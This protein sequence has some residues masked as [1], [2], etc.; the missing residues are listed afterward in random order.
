MR[1]VFRYLGVFLLWNLVAGFFLFFA[2]PVL[3]IPISLA[4]YAAII[5]GY[6]LR[7]RPGE[8]AIRRRALV[9]LR[10]LTGPALGWTLASV[11]V[12]LLL[13]WS[14]SDVYTRL[15]PVPSSSL[16]PFG[17]LLETPAG[18]LM[19]TIFAI[20]IA[21]VVEEFFFRGLIQRELELRYGTVAGILGG[22]G[23]FAGVHLLPWVFPLH[24]FLGAA[25]GYAVWA[26]RSIWAG[27]ILHT[28]NNVA[29]M[30]TFSYAGEEPV[31][32]GTFWEFGV[33]AELGVSL[34]ALVAT[35]SA[36]I[37]MAGKMLRLRRIPALPVD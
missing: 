34:V 26:T 23:F 12:L 17:E 11:P 18:M 27:I 16:N 6:V 8:S 30:L 20:A 9:R 5:M 35:A 10:P 4:L 19:I 3:A 13:S 1:R 32:T 22:A 33:T 37:W 36:A 24:L 7:P 15:V 14:L 28:A 21:P 25:F 29:A 31:P 2:E